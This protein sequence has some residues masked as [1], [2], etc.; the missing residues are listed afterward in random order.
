MT[1]QILKAKTKDEKVATGLSDEVRESV[2]ELLGEV[3]GNTI[4]LQV[5]TQVYHWNVVGP[6]FYPLHKLT[7]E[8]YNNLFAAADEIA[9][10]I[11]AIGHMAPLSIKALKDHADIQEETA[12]RS[13]GEMVSQLIEDHEKLIRTA[14]DAAREA[15]EGGDFVTHDLLTERLAFH[16]QA[17]WMLRATMA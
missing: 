10:R 9:E 12:S 16:E 13:A 3:L 8:H 15:E 1:A 6:L 4:I 7:E 5:K 14:R 17:V 2:A 11:R